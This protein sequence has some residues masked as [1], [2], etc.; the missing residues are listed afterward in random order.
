[1]GFRS[2]VAILISFKNNKK[3]II[4]FKSKI[5]ELLFKAIDDSNFK[6][7]LTNFYQTVDNKKYIEFLFADKC[8]KSEYL[9]TSDLFEILNS[10]EFINYEMIDLPDCYDNDGCEH[11]QNDYDNESKLY[12]D[13]FIEGIPEVGDISLLDFIKM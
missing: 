13:Y 5:N 11:I 6:Y 8:I 9:P 10:L 4:N 12:I 2:D 7:L 3:N 1:M